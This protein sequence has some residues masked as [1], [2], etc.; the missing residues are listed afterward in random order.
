MEI[1]RDHAKALIHSGP[2]ER[3]KTEMGSYNPTL[4]GWGV[5]EF[6]DLVRLLKLPQDAPKE[7]LPMKDEGGWGPMHIRSWWRNRKRR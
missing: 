3:A 5:C 4:P 6:C 2:C 7:G 1:S